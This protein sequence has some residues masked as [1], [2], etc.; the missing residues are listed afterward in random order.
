M[1]VAIGFLP[2]LLS[3]WVMQ[4]KRWQRRLQIRRHATIFPAHRIPEETRTF[5][6][7]RYYLEGF[8]YLIGDISCEYNAHSGYL[9]C[10]VNP[11]GPCDNCRSYE[12]RQKVTYT[13]NGS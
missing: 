6:N 4:K 1:V 10:A 2:S 8:G 5:P 3:L 13:R 11:E 7:D 9:R 12:A